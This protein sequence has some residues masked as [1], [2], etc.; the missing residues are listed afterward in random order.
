MAADLELRNI[1]NHF[2]RLKNAGKKVNLYVGCEAGGQVFVNFQAHLGPVHF[3][4]Q[5]ED[6]RHRRHFRDR[7]EPRHC[8]EDTHPKKS[9]PS[10]VRRR[11][12]RENARA[13]A[14]ISAAK[15]A[16][17]SESEEDNDSLS[18]DTVTLLPIPPTTAVKVV[19]ET[20][21]AVAEE[22][23]QTA[24]Q[25]V[26]ASKVL[27][28]ASK[29]FSSFRFQS[30]QYPP[31]HPPTSSPPRRVRRTTP[32]PAPRDPLSIRKPERI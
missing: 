30:L 11:V 24:E 3:H 27:P 10:R 8:Q 25:A 26:L 15:A 18:V 29:L 20:T 16:P 2:Y 21:E 19:D 13:E 9:T 14:K 23:A 22:A 4:S 31:P 12:K 28:F 17:K 32:R 7:E 6:H 5:E 1:F